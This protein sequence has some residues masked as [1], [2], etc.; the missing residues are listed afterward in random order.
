MT[1]DFEESVKVMAEN[2]RRKKRTPVTASASLV[3][4]SVKKNSVL[5]NENIELNENSEHVHE[6]KKQHPAKKRRDA[7][8]IVTGNDIDKMVNTLR[9]KLN[10]RG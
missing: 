1:I 3:S 4:A 2:V 5:K 7:R 8:K 9:R 10:N 6:V